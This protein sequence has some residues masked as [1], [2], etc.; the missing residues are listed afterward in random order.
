MDVIHGSFLWFHSI[1]ESRFQKSL[2][3]KL[4]ELKQ[5]SEKLDRGGILMIKPCSENENKKVL[6]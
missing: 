2:T 1:E 5:F 3:T 4:F 6:S